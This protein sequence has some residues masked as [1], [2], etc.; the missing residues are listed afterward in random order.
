MKS[1]SR[2]YNICQEI[3]GIAYILDAL[4]EELKLDQDIGM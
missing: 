1:P 3:R 4:K 2:L